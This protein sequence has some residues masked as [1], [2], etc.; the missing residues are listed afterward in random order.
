MRVSFYPLD[1]GDGVRHCF[2]FVDLWMH[3]RDF[4]MEVICESG[5]G[6]C[7]YLHKN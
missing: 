3:T 5:L 7:M 4:Q 2:L 1:D 6:W